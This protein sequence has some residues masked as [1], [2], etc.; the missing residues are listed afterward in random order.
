MIAVF[1]QTLEQIVAL[2]IPDAIVASMGGNAGTQTLTVAVRAIAM[3]EFD[4]RNAMR[5]IAKEILVGLLNGV[6][7]ALLMGAIAGFWF[8]SLPLGLVIAAA[9]VLN[10]V[11]AGMAGALIPLL[12]DRGVSI[13][14]LPPAS[15]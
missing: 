9:M 14:P 7:F 8:S 4:S 12:L 15:S 13:L 6:L 10:L 1:A 3:R 2:A 11:V 5:F